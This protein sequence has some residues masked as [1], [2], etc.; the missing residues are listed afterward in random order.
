MSLPLQVQS[1]LYH[2]KRRILAL[3]AAQVFS[4]SC[5]S[6]LRVNPRGLPGERHH[7]KTA[8][9]IGPLWPLSDPFTPGDALDTSRV[10]ARRLLRS[11]PHVA[12]HQPRLTHTPAGCG[13]GGTRNSST[14]LN[15]QM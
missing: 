11:P 5:P 3:V 13:H 15:V 12:S 8:L 9:P 6:S 14:S 10:D 2:F 7:G 4:G 1:Q